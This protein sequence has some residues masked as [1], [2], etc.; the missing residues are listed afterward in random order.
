LLAIDVLLVPDMKMDAEAAAL[1]AKLRENYPA[2]YTLGSEQVAHI[3]LVHR[4]IKAK[5]LPAIERAVTKLAV[6]Q[7]PLS[8]QLTATGLGHGVWAGVAIT[9]IDV[10]PTPE[11]SRLQS[12]VVKA[13]EPYAV[14]G[15]TAS[16]FSESRELPKIDHEIVDY[17]E[18]FVRKS[19]GPKFN[20]HVTVGVAHEDFVKKLEAA[21]FKSLTFRPAA[22]AIYQLGNF[23]TAQ[24]KLW[25]WKPE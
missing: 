13:V 25:E 10:K 2:G 15:G 22:L 1:N 19:S 24:K 20:P 12:D 18:N 6:D 7:K 11:L 23:G 8:W 9:T 3:T 16:A 4:Y 17:V 14:H 21:P 5:D